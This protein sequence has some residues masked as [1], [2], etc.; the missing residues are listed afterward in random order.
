MQAA[1]TGGTDDSGDASYQEL[2]SHDVRL[3]DLQ[4]SVVGPLDVTAKFGSAG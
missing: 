4:I 2:S 3:H 1:S